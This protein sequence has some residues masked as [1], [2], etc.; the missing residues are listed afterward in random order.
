MLIKSNYCKFISIIEK[1]GK[2][3]EKWQVLIRKTVFFAV[4]TKL[5]VKIALKR[6]RSLKFSKGV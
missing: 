4:K 6:S 2:F 5:T 1:N 3:C